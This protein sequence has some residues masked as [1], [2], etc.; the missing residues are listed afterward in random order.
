MT[1][2]F[3][4]GTAGFIGRELV[5]LA[6]AGGC[7]VFG[8]T[9]SEPPAQRIQALGATPVIGDLN[10]PD[11]WQPVVARCEFVVH[12]A[13]PDTYGGRVTQSRARAYG[14]KRLRTGIPDVVKR[15]QVGR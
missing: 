7:Q 3:V 11:T 1:A 13:Q 14:E 12:L 6:V 5:R 4:T 8:L 15:W 10:R 9:C 2:I